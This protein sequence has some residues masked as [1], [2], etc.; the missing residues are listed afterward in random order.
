MHSEKALTDFQDLERSKSLQSLASFL[1][2][3]M[4][5]EFREKEKAKI[6]LQKFVSNLLARVRKDPAEGTVTVFSGQSRDQLRQRMMLFARFLGFWVTDIYDAQKI[7]DPIGPG[8]LQVFL[9]TLLHAR[10][11]QCPLLEAGQKSYKVRFDEF[12]GAV[13]MVLN[14]VR[15]HEREAIKTEI[16]DMNGRDDMI[17]LE[18][19]LEMVVDV[20]VNLD[21]Q[22]NSRLEALFVCHDSNGDGDL[23]TYE[24]H[25]MM[26]KLDSEAY[27]NDALNQRRIYAKMCLY[28]RVDAG[29]FCRTAREHG[30][31]AFKIGRQRVLS[32]K[33]EGTGVRLIPVYTAAKNAIQETISEISE[34]P[35]YPVMMNYW[36]L[37]ESLVRGRQN[38]EIAW[39]AFYHASRLY[40]SMMNA[41]RRGETWGQ[42]HAKKL[43]MAAA[44]PE[45]RQRIGRESRLNAAKKVVRSH[46]YDKMSTCLGDVAAGVLGE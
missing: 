20:W 2:M 5:K 44:S 11:G 8:G 25:D 19:S 22:L 35:D 17:D 18:V 43:E 30:L 33:Q 36:A 34:C 23:D 12:V 31:A 40:S 7:Y 9:S 42:G 41:L 15:F 29:V 37:C 32:S 4:L 21:S 1:W 6:E 13:D 45:S 24:Y 16:A 38:P 39:V 14:E 28:Q 3:Y 26:R 10:E 46:S 27:V